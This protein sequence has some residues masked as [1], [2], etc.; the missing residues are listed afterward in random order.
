MPLTVARTPKPIPRDAA[1]KTA[2]AVEFSS[3][4]HTP[5]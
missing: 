2:A 5:V 4:S 1:G 3:V